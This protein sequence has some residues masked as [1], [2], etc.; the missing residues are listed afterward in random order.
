MNEL[1]EQLLKEECYVI[2]FLPE[3]VSEQYAE[4]FL[5]VEEYFL[6]GNEWI[7]IKDSFVRILLKLQCYCSFRV[8]N[9]HWYEEFSICELADMLNR[10][11]TSSNGYM[12]MLSIDNKLLICIEGFA[13]NLS[14]Y[15]ATEDMLDLL[16]EMARTEGLYIRKSE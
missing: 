15:N 3:R 13:L 5:E 6:Q 1:V 11:L 9:E 2:D 10:V 16:S 8:Y 4:R 14:I 12:N 7:R